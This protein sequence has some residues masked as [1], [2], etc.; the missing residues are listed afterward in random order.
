MDK[1]VLTIGVL[2]WN[3]PEPLYELISSL[4]ASKNSLFYKVLV[5]DDCSSI[6]VAK[7]LEAFTSNP[8][9]D[10]EIIRNKINLG[11]AN[12]FRKAFLSTD[13]E[14]L[15]MMSHDDLVLTENI[16]YILEDIMSSKAA[17][18]SPIFLRKGKK[19]RGRSFGNNIRPKDF[20][21]ASSHAPGLIYK[22]DICTMHFDSMK[23]IFDNDS[24]PLRFYPQVSLVA[25]LMLNGHSCK[26]I[27]KPSAIEN[28]P[29]PSGLR[30]SETETYSSLCPRW[31]QWVAFESF[32]TKISEGLQ[33][34]NNF[35][36][37]EMKIAIGSLSFGFFLNA[38]KKDLPASAK[39]F[40]RGAGVYIIKLTIKKVFALNFLRLHF[41]SKK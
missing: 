16:H 20:F 7:T 6:P 32:F 3:S 17:F 12:N 25:V 23:E 38:I 35:V 41:S 33:K 34:P 15:M 19:Y 37:Q 31:Q 28:K 27:R 13:T 2:A 39:Y 21:I 9:N 8:N 5:C 30:V 40:V 18:Y 14:Y 1:K 24:H 4:L 22:V 26:W 10:I 36:M 29:S 11:F